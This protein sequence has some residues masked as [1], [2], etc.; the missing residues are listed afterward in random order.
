MGKRVLTVEY[1]AHEDHSSREAAGSRGRTRSPVGS[2]GRRTP[3]PRGRARRSPVYSPRRRSP[4]P[5]G[6]S[7]DRRRSPS[8]E[9]CFGPDGGEAEASK[10]V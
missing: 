5:R 6:R 8:R 10:L 7:Y 1:V 3:S 4:N 9:C 2:H